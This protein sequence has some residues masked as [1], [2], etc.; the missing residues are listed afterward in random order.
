MGM[1]AALKLKRI[2]ENSR[3]AMA[4]NPCRGQA[5]DFLSSA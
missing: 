5:L 3:N 2:V 1:T 4:I